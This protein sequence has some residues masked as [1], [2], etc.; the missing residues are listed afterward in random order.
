VLYEKIDDYF[1]TRLRRGPKRHTEDHIGFLSPQF[2]RD[3][4]PVELLDPP[5]V[6]GIDDLTGNYSKECLEVFALP[7]QPFSTL[8]RE[9]ATRNLRQLP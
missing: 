3:E 9:V 2:I 7:E 8:I 6:K 5:K 4:T 1:L